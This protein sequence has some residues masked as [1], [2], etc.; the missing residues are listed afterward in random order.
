MTAS[1]VPGQE[2]VPLLPEA[3]TPAPMDVVQGAL[4]DVKESEHR[5]KL[6]V[7]TAAAI[8]TAAV[9]AAKIPLVTAPTIALEALQ[10]T[11]SPFISGAVTGIVFGSWTLG[12]SGVINAAGNHYPEAKQRVKGRY[13]KT[14]SLLSE[15][16]PGLHREE[17]N[18]EDKGRIAKVRDA[19]LLHAKRGTAIVGVGASFYIVAAQLEEMP[20]EEVKRLRRLAS[21]DGALVIG[22]ISVATAGVVAKIS[23]S[24]PELA[25]RIHDGATDTKTLFALAASL[26]IGQGLSKWRSKRKAKNDNKEY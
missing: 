7:T 17:N 21:M 19:T 11:D 25:D 20:K 16:L 2:H 5:F 24:H 1:E 8:G 26:I 6:V 12:A 9:N 13:P 4:I 22:S 15:S 3:T 23:D 10:Y 14:A 18:P